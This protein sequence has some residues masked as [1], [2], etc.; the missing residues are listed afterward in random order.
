MNADLKRVRESAGLTQAQLSKKTKIPSHQIK[1]Y[2]LGVKDFHAAN[3]LK[4]FKGCGY[5]FQIVPLI[6]GEGEE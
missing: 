1:M 5:T 6:P 4:L 2:E 3:L